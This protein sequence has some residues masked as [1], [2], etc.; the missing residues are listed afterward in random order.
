MKLTTIVNAATTIAV[1]APIMIPVLARGVM[2]PDPLCTTLHPGGQVV[3][4]NRADHS[5]NS[6]A[7][8][9]V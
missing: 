9:A 2:A 6:A 8:N 3:R 5:V 1:Q 4:S 7:P